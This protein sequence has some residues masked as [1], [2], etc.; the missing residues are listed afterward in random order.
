MSSPRSRKRREVE[1]HDVQPMEQI[2]AEIAGGDGLHDVAVGRGDEPD[3]DPQFLRAADAGE[4]AVFEKAQQLGLQRLAHVGDFIEK[5]RA[6][7]GF[8]DAPQFL[9]RTRR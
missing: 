7:I 1:L 2:F 5:N 4:R 3:I 9:F 6:A 8:L